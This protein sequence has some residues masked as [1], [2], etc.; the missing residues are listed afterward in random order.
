MTQRDTMT[1]AHEPFGD[2]WY[3]GPEKLGERYQNDENRGR[4]TGF[5]DV[6]YRAVLDGFEKD[7]AQVRCTPPF[8]DPKANPF[9][10]VGS[11]ASPRT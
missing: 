6:T 4:K 8:H 3:F 1:C 10:P 9:F 11:S 2:A 7:T 5:R